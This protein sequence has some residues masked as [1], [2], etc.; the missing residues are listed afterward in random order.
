MILKLTTRRRGRESCAA[1]ML[2]PPP[3]DTEEWG[4]LGGLAPPPNSTRQKRGHVVTHGAP[5]PGGR[6]GQVS[7]RLL[8]S[9][10]SGSASP[11]GAPTKT[12]GSALPVRQLVRCCRVPRVPRQV[13]KG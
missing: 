12:L 4:G 3:K 13:R 10:L 7:R 1:P 11:L 5:G 6:R 2:R 9:Q 8:E